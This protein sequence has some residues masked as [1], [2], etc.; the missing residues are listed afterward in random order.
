[1]YIYMCDSGHVALISLTALF[2]WPQPVSFHGHPEDSRRSDGGHWAVGYNHHDH[3]E[4][5]KESVV[6]ARLDVWAPRIYILD[7]SSMDGEMTCVYLEIFCLGHWGD[8]LF[9]ITSLD[10]VIYYSV[11]FKRL[12]WFIVCS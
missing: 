12:Q 6:M 3:E 11:D 8:S 2:L 10:V 5:P 9:K 7:F 1:M 4:C